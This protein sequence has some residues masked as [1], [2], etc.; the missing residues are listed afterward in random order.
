MGGRFVLKNI[1][2]K[3]ILCMIASW[4]GLNCSAGLIHAA[5]VSVSAWDNGNGTYSVSVSSPYIGGVN[6]STTYGNVQFWCEGSCVVTSGS[7]TIKGT[8]TISIN[9]IPINPMSDSNASKITVSGASTYI[10][11]KNPNDVVNKP[12]TGGDSSGSAQNIN[13]SNEDEPKEEVKKNTDSALASLSVSDGK[14]SPNFASGTTSYKVTLPSTASSIKISASARDAKASVSGTGTRELEPGNN[15]LSVVC[16][17]ED[18]SSTTY[19]I[20]VY[21]DEK[22]LTYMTYNGVKFGVS[23]HNGKGGKLSKA[24]DETKIKVDGIEIPAWKNKALNITLVYLQSEGT[25][26]YYIYDETKQEVVSV[27]EPM[28]VLGQNIV[29]IDVP[30]NLQKREGMNF[31]KVKVDGKEFTGW[32]FDD[33]NL[34]NYALIYVMN[35]AGKYVYYQYEKTQN[36][37]QLYSGSAPLSQEAFV[38]YKEDM[39]KK[40][41]NSQMWNVIFGIA[42]GIFAVGMIASIVVASK[43]KSTSLKYERVN[44]PARKMSKASNIEADSL[45]NKFKDEE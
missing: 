36:T 26:G 44:M 33:K 18:G 40:L 42:A 9:A 30:E 20:N 17:A 27:Y 13:S 25:E 14:L 37:L 41:D 28:A 7:S 4:L 29:R 34:E 11:V 23:A 35:D 19:T 1:L 39:E 5:S 15:K 45:M 2:K 32:T 38:K 31:T 8:G 21:V 3:L 12:N 6:V 22:P 43:R 24:F 16:S 10:N